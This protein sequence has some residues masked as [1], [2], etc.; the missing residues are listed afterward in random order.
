MHSRNL[1]L[2]TDSRAW[3]R[4]AGGRELAE[5]LSVQTF[6]K[7]PLQLSKSSCSSGSAY[8]SVKLKLYF[9]A[10]SN[11]L[12]HGLFSHALIVLETLQPEMTVQVLFWKSFRK[13][14][15]FAPKILECFPCL[16]VITNGNFISYIN[17]Q[18]LLQFLHH[19]HCE[20]NVLCSQPSLLLHFAYHSTQCNST[21]HFLD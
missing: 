4:A 16:I 6:Q 9:W 17:T 19:W 21:W 11:V 15:C 3:D 14:Q 8:A 13:A 12:F 7:Q 18:T 5:Q 1:V 20:V 10:F 2:V